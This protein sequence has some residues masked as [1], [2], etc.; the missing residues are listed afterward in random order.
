[1]AGVVSCPG[2]R[3]VPCSR[4]PGTRH[5]RRCGT[6]GERWR[7]LA[8]SGCTRSTAGDSV[9]PA[10]TRPSWPMTAPTRAG[11]STCPSRASSS[12]TR[13][14]PHVGHGHVADPDRPRRLGDAGARASWASCGPLD[15]APVDIRFLAVSHGHWDHSGN[16][17][18]FAGS[19]WIVNP[20][21]RAFMFDDENRASRV[22]GRLRRSRGRGHAPGHRRSRRLRRRIG[23]HPPG[24]RATPPATPCCWC[25][26]PMLGRSSSPA[27]CGT[28]RRA[29]VTDWRCPSTTPIA[30]R[31]LPR[32]TGSRRWWTSTGAR[33]IVQ[34]E[35]ADQE[36]LPR[37][38]SGLR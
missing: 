26:S 24:A 25:G 16:A 31:R 21:E 12:G 20:V 5:G 10:R 18:L 23:G 19:T 22:D 2:R 13:R 30:R 9:S 38:P 8:R 32:W 33:V 11:R 34:H 7:H 17:G 27:T 15:L 3:P 36:S 1:M 28:R 35:L 37:F 29:D 4:R 14:R 6:R